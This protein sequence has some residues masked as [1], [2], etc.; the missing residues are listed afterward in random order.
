MRA[1]GH[2][3]V[4]PPILVLF[5]N[6]IF[7]HFSLINAFIHCR[8]VIIIIFLIVHST[9]MRRG[10]HTDRHLIATMRLIDRHAAFLFFFILIFIY[11]IPFFF[12]F[13]SLVLSGFV[14]EQTAFKRNLIIGQRGMYIVFISIVRRMCVV[15]GEKCIL[16]HAYAVLRYA[17]YSEFVGCARAIQHTKARMIMD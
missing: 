11:V 2:F 7:I 4:G 8:S 17:K 1:H 3:N 13:D 5:K 15:R 6:P 9:K 16:L 12:S 10:G 14:S